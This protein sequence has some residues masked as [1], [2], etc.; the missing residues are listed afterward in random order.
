MSQVR[1]VPYC[2]CV[3]AKNEAARLPTLIAALAA[4]DV[5]GP[6]TVVLALN[7][8]TDASREVLQ[9]A[10]RYFAPRI[11][12]VVDD[13]DFMPE[14]AHVG[15]A[16]RRAMDIGSELIGYHPYGVLLT[17]D[18]DARPPPNWV[19]NNLTAIS[20]WRD[21]VGGHLVIDERE[22]LPPAVQTVRVLWD[23]YWMLVRAVE[24]SIDPRPYDPPPR[25]GDHT[26]GSLALTVQLYQGCGG[27]PVVPFN[28]DHGLVNAALAVGG[29]VKHPMS[30]WTRVSPRRDGRARCGM[31]DAMADL[32]HRV[33]EG[34]TIFAPSL[35]H[36][37]ARALWRR[38]L[39][40]LNGGELRLAREEALLPP[41]P[42]DLPLADVVRSAG[43][44]RRSELLRNRSQT[45][46]LT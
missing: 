30:V 43:L 27:V 16:R 46:A 7:N 24:D 5:Q 39:R 12:V 28:E 13:H 37:R 42:H 34:E 25:H 18:A 40:L 35:A 15:S 10:S 22:A 3:P 8:T 31:A 14:L 17:T 32:F 4:Q 44:G 26:G 1:D 33:A 41:M 45:P 36:W 2:V 11:R 6:V 38:D 9:K 20:D 29:R 21:I 19:R 23:R